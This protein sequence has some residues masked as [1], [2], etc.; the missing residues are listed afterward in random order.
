[1]KNKKFT[2]LDGF[3][4]FSVKNKCPC[5]DPYVKLKSINQKLYLSH[6]LEKNSL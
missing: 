3:I 6:T 5:L 1:M 4:F 2:G